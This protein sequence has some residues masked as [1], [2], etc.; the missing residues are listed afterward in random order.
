[1]ETNNNYEPEEREGTVEERQTDL[2][3]SSSGE[4]EPIN[5]KKEIF[6]WI[7]IIVVAVVIAFVINNFIIMNANVP[8]G[9]MMNTIMKG[10]RM[11]GL[12]TSYWFSDPKRGDIVIFENPDY[13]ENSKLD[14]RYYVKRVIGLPGEK[15]VIKDAKIYINDSETPLDEPYLPEEWTYVNGSDE[16]LVYNVPD[17]CYFMLGDNRN[18]SSDARFWTNTYLKREK[19][20]AKAQFIYWRWGHKGFYEKVEYA[21]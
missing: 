16:E 7:K 3:N 6:S 11:I 13:N 10:D 15:V 14:D 19:V 8:S 5:V 18:N 4:K 12:R 1:M 21:E 20:I 17:G 2:E 9:S